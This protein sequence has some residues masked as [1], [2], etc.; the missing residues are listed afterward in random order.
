MR[1]V[2]LKQSHEELWLREGYLLA[3]QFAEGWVCLRIL[4]W[5][6]S[7]VKPYRVAT[8]I[9][10]G[11]QLAA[12]DE[13]K[14]SEARRY[15]EPPDEEYI[16]HYFFGINHPRARVYFQYPSRRDR[17]SLVAVERAVGGDVGYVD[18][19]MSPYDGPFSLKSEFFTVSELYPAFQVYNPLAD[20]IYNVLLNFDVMRY[21]YQVLKDSALVQR[22]LLGEVRRRMYT[23]GGVDPSP[24]SAPSWLQEA[25]GKE[26]M[27]WT[28]KLMETGG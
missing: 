6:P 28:Q 3:M 26:L 12:W 9:A 1:S 2:L 21:T 25:A 18:G 24:V 20:T 14:D 15:T 4:G 17:N 27:A 16:H 5:E 19:E 23:V 22:I 7:N 11:G 13:I 8:S 10:A